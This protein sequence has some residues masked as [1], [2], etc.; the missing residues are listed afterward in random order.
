MVPGPLSANEELSN[1]LRELLERTRDDLDLPGLRAAVRL[2]DESLVAE[3]VGLGDR[4]AETP[5]TN[6]IGM[7]GGSTGKTFCAALTMLLVEDEVLGLDDFAS[8]FLSDEK[9]YR[10]V[11]N[12]DDIQV[13]HLLAHTAGMVQYTDV[14]RY[15]VWSIWR[16]I[17]RGGIKFT[18]EELIRIASRHKP[19]FN[20]GEGYSYTDAGYLILGHIIETATGR[21][22]YELL[23]E[24]VIQPLG[25]NEVRFQ[26]VSALPDIVPGYQ[27][28]ARNLR[29][30]GTM[31]IDPTSEW[32]GGGLVL[33]PTMLVRFYA[34]LAN[35]EV[36]SDESFQ[37]MISMGYRDSDAPGVGYGLGVFV[38]DQPPVIEHGGLWPGY[39]SHVRHYL[40]SDITIAIQ[41]NQDGPIDMESIT[42]SIKELVQLL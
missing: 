14:N 7:P 23:D 36:V 28:G 17:R 34:A 22:Y 35:G 29:K 21:D 2:P 4:E 19:L 31:K 38:S 26:N 32:T 41:T 20:V 9:W 27:R 39:R 3:A 37:Q 33:N 1:S 18:S 11:P 40:D 6:E 12:A 24:R 15:W 5:L 42:D 16:A 25:L 8:S 13:K 10:K 30:D